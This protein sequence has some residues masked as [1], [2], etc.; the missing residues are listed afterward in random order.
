MLAMPAVAQNAPA[1]VA[2]PQSLETITVT[3]SN[4]RRVDI[5]TANPVITIDRAQID[6]TGHL[7]IGDVLQDL[8]SIAGAGDNPRVNN[9][10]G[11]GATISLRGLGSQRTLVLINGHRM[12]GPA[13]DITQIPI[14]LVERIEV[15]A[16]G[17]SAV[18]GSDAIAGVVNVI[19]RS[20]YQ[21]AEF[22]ADYGIS[23]HD[24]GA[25]KGVNFTFGH[26]TEKGSITAGVH[27]EKFDSIPAANR[28]FSSSAMY[29]RSGPR[30]GGSARNP[31]G[32]V[33]LPPNLVDQFGCNAVS[34]NPGTPA[35]PTTIGDY[36]C[37]TFAGDSFN[38]Q[39][40]G[41]YNLIAQER[42]GLFMVGNYKLSDS[43]SAYLE[44]FHNKSSANTQGAP[45]PFDAAVDNVH[46]SANNYYNP[47][48]IGFGNGA[49]EVN[50]LTRFSAVG[51]RSN[52]LEFTNDQVNVGLKG[53]VGDSTWQW[54]ANYSYGHAN[55]TVQRNGYIYYKGLQ[56]ALGPSF[57]DPT[58][59]N[60]AGGVVC[61]TPGNVIAGCTPINIF[62]S[63][64]P[65]TV[66]AFR[67][68][69]AG[70][71][72]NTFYIQREGDV[73]ANGELFQLPAGAVNLA[74]GATER[75]EYTRLAVD[76]IA[77]TSGEGATCY[78][79][80][81]ICRTP[82]VGDFTV[83]EL[84]AE[85]LVPVLK[86]VPFVHSLNLT[87]GDRYSKYTTVG[88]T[89]NWKVALEWRPIEDLLLRGTVSKVF[90]APTLNELYA[91]ATGSAPA[92]ADPCIGQTTPNP[93]CAGVPLDGNFQGDGLGQTTGV[94]TGGVPAGVT[95]KPE[96]GKSFDFGVVYD[97]SWLEGLSVSADLWRIYLNDLIIGITAQ[98]ILN[99]CYNSSQANPSPYCGFI[100]RRDAGVQAGNLRFVN[101]PTVNLGRL[102][103]KGVDFAFHY[104]LPETPFGKFKLN[105]QSTYVA[106]YDNDQNAGAGP[107]AVISVAGH[108]NNQFGNIARWRALAGVDWNYGNFDATVTAKYIG[109]FALG[110]ADGTG[111]SADQFVPNVELHYGSN[112]YLN[113]TGGYNI[114]PI[115]AR[116]EVGVD[117]VANRTPPILYQ[118]N[119][120]NSNTDVATFDTIGRYYWG[121]F[122]VKF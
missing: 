111:P 104:R 122:T 28:D 100:H 118:N 8:P 98:T 1:D 23:D 53:A 74:V 46:I 112:T 17:A 63:R 52:A 42:T 10:G 89:S 36:H 108:Y 39:S 48:G 121:R 115:N 31:N 87:L 3:G 85:A 86:D 90:R 69:A 55:N 27:Y 35:G 26:T 11:G 99:L 76:F 45:V 51:V 71:F 93:A 4:I 6:R 54:S 78:V 40:I 20:E 25:R 120:L 84:Y 49:D 113:L 109:R 77:I 96:F 61:G 14:N 22:S 107:P 33:T 47:F 94:T 103:T 110:W 105:F 119:V 5:E 56:D 57:F 75:K 80:Q 114:V 13:P 102:D 95:L 24:D 41:N 83:K 81:E 88:N 38:F 59:N 19:L 2:A 29:L 16:D 7:N 15:L 50:F 72:Y 9:G 60:G 68:V 58:A 67:A 116:I 18:Y 37:Y 117:N 34:L 62:N 73:Q 79:S 12:T 32:Q 66:A 91:G 64:D 44:A 82:A 21:D 92:I 30:I 97:P 101:Q 65:A 43:V 106:Q 70:P